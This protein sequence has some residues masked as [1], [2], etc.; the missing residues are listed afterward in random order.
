MIIEFIKRYV[1][2]VKKLWEVEK[3]YIKRVSLVLKSFGSH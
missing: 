1:R 3:R 2:F